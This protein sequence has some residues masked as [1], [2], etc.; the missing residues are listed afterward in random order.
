[1]VSPRAANAARMRTMTSEAFVV[2]TGVLSG[3]V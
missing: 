2:M 3:V 1:M